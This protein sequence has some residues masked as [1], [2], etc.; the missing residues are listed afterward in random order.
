MIVLG[1]DPGIN[2]SSYA[3]IDG[4]RLY[5]GCVRVKHTT[6]DSW[7]KLE[8]MVSAVQ[9][10]ILDQIYPRFDSINLY[11]CEGQYSR[12]G[13][14]TQDHNIR[15]GWISGAVYSMALPGGGTDRHIALPQ[16]WTKGKPKEMREAE[17]LEAAP[18]REEWIW[19][20]KEP[21][22]SEFHNIIDA[23]GLAQYG[24]QERNRHAESTS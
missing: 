6:R 21:P 9:R 13:R 14:G 24:L 17:V 2:I 16:R 4:D 19:L 3:I 11:V 10:E 5:V 23:I 22:K 1:F 20:S 12:P 15:L 7:E 8:A 18:P